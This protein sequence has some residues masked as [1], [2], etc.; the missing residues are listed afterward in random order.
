MSY[1]A[2]VKGPHVH[3]HSVWLYWGV[4]FAL[5]LLTILT[6]MQAQYDFGELSIILTLIIASTKALLVM[7]FFMHLAYDSK[8]FAV[9]AC[10]SLGFLS[11]FIFFSV[12]D[13]ASR[14]DLDQEQV[15][16]LPRNE[17]VYKHERTNPKALPLRPGLSEGQKDDLVFIGPGEH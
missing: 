15:N 2:M 9:I 3:P 5:V 14:A 4:F 8:F 11:L 13:L 6:V 10:A 16:F 1:I 7:G 12:A 17:A